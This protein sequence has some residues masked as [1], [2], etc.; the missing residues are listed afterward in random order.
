MPY[1]SDGAND[2]LTCIKT[3]CHALAISI[4]LTAY[5]AEDAADDSTTCSMHTILAVI[6]PIDLLTGL[7]DHAWCCR[8]C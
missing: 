8:C 2:K 1:V 4:I 3:R 5:D 7:H 6:M